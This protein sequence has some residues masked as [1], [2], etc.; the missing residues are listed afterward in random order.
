MREAAGVW[1]DVFSI[2]EAE[3]HICRQASGLSALGF[4]HFT[5][6][7]LYFTNKQTLGVVLVIL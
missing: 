7:K 1:A 5:L 6:C 4:V 3:V 2:R